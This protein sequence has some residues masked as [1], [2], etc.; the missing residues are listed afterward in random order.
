MDVYL[1][2]LIRALFPVFLPVRDPYPGA[3]NRYCLWNHHCGDT[4]ISEEDIPADREDCSAD[5]V[6]VDS[7]CILWLFCQ[8]SGSSSAHV[9]LSH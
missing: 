7:R 4:A 2:M 8:L 3:N 6:C 5:C 9:G 1:Y